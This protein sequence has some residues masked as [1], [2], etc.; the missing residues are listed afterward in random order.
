MS[1]SSQ[2]ILL[3]IIKLITQWNTLYSVLLILINH[4][5]QYVRCV[6]YDSVSCNGKVYPNHYSMFLNETFLSWGMVHCS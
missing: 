6:A 5:M 4:V 3:Y 2:F 1:I